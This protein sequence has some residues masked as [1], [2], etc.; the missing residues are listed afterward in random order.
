MEQSSESSDNRAAFQG[1]YAKRAGY[2]G[3]DTQ[4]IDRGCTFSLF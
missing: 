2:G 4:N 3:G 1:M